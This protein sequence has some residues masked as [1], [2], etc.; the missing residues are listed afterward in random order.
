MSKKYINLLP[1]W[2]L[3]SW[4][5]YMLGAWLSRWAQLDLHLS[6]VIMIAILWVL[7]LGEIYHNGFIQLILNL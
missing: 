5:V 1:F 2:F 6:G 3:A 4:M 7:I